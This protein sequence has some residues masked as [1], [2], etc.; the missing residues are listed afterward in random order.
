MAK[1]E[2]GDKVVFVAESGTGDSQSRKGDIGIV[3]SVQENALGCLIGVTT[4]RGSYILTYES[5]WERWGAQKPAVLDK[6]EGFAVGDKVKMINEGE[7]ENG[8][9]DVVFG[10]IGVIT[11]F[12]DVEYQGH[13]QWRVDFPNQSNWLA[14]ATVDIVVVEKAKQFSIEE[15]VAGIKEA[16]AQRKELKTKIKQLKAVLA[17]GGVKLV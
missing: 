9:G 3:E 13:S 16:Q 11:K 6:F 8:L 10:D 1:F 2:A 4:E 17:Q 5:R 14:I 12:E 7:P 15:A